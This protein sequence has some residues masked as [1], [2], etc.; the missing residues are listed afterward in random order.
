MKFNKLSE[1]SAHFAKIMIDALFE[2]KSIGFYSYSIAT[3]SDYYKKT[4][5]MVPFN[6]STI[7]KKIMVPD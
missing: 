4:F 2:T 1:K 6:N 3:Q 7:N 5:S